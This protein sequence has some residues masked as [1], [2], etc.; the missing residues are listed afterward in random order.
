GIDVFNRMRLVAKNNQSLYDRAFWRWVAPPAPPVG[1]T[2]RQMEL[3]R[4]A[5]TAALIGF[6]VII[7][8][9]PALSSPTRNT[10]LT[11][12]GVVSLDLFAILYFNRKGQL[13][14]AGILILLASHTG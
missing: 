11:V 2:H 8:V 12:I 3:H 7:F 1:A 4:R 5:K 9:L 6:V 10:I 13:I 14:R